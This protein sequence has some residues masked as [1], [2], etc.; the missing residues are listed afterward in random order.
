VGASARVITVLR[1]PMSEDLVR[2][3]GGPAPNDSARRTSGLLVEG[4]RRR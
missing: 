1:A 3:L 4:A 2:G